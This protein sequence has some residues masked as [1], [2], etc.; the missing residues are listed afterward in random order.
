MSHKAPKNYGKATK[1]KAT[2]TSATPEEER[3]AK[4]IISGIAIGLAVI[5]AALVL[6]YHFFTK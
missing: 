1:A 4:R 2:K 6:A 5:C 3:Q